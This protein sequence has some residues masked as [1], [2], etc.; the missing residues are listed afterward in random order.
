MEV[1]V[2][3]SVS[4]HKGCGVQTPEKYY[5]CNAK[6]CIQVNIQLKKWAAAILKNLHAGQQFVVLFVVYVEVLVVSRKC[7]NSVMYDE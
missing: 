5:I 3:W 6:S 2:G 1:G 4:L 7:L